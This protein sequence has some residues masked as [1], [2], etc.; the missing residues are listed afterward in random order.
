MSRSLPALGVL[1]AAL[2][3]VPAIRAQDAPP[4]AQIAVVDGLVTLERESQ[5]QDAGANVPFLPGDQLKTTQGRVEVLFADGSVLDLDEYSSLDLQSLDPPILLR[6]TTGRA[7]LTIP[8]I[9]DPARAAA[10]QIDTPAG[11]VATEGPGEYRLSLFSGPEVELA[12]FRGSASLWTD[13]GATRVVA[14]ER[15][16]ARELAAP[17]TPRRFNS[18]RFDAFDAWSAARADERIGRTSA[19]Y[20]P[21]NLHIYGGTLDR[22]GSWYYEAPYG[23]VWYPAVPTGWRPYFRGYW[24]PLRVYGWTW[25]GLDVWAWPTHH[26]GRWGHARGRWFWIPGPRWGPA[27][28]TWAAAPGYVS[29]C[30]LGFDNRPVFALNIG[31]VQRTGWVVLPRRHFGGRGVYVDR[32]AVSSGPVP[33]H[34]AFTPLAAPPVPQRAVPR[35][36]DNGWAA[37]AVGRERAVPRSSLG[38]VTGD[39]TAAAAQGAGGSAQGGAVAASPLSPRAAGARVRAGGAGPARQASGA[40]PSAAAAPASSAPGGAIAPGS[41]T[42]R[43][44]A[45]AASRPSGASPAAPRAVP[46][47]AGSGSAPAS[48]SRSSSGREAASPGVSPPA[49]GPSAPVRGGSRAVPRATSPRSVPA[50]SRSSSRREAVAPEA[51]PTP[52]GPTPSGG[53]RAVPRAAPRTSRSPDAFRSPEGSPT[54]AP[55]PATGSRGTVRSTTPAATAAPLRPAPAPGRA[56]GG[57]RAASPAGSGAPAPSAP[58]SSAARGPRAVSRGDGGSPSPAAAPAPSRQGSPSRAGTATGARRAR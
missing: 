52:S 26:Y 19:E 53:V 27:W 57:S 43:A 28:V 38:P 32:F 58:A 8:G 51:S 7:L 15:S 11:S 56:G 5:T 31:I 3:A 45:A 2:A 39:G 54:E 17:S 1:A 9:A 23:H 42:N 4:P 40:V 35:H 46:R 50:E 16:F 33:V 25:V 24:S 29:W 41:R 47:A 36:A 55:R 18:A 13:Q 22:H 34:T 10:F 44:A 30:P 21:P 14:G 48:G 20:L 6:L 49:S 12:V 37:T